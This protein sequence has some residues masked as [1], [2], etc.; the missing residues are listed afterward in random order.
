M[1][2]TAN[3]PVMLKELK[4][5]AIAR[6]WDRLAQDEKALGWRH[7]QYLSA[8]CELEVANRHSRRLA[9]YHKESKLPPGKSLSSFDFDQAVG[10]NRAHIDALAANVDWVGQARNLLL[11]GASGLGK[12][13]LACAIGASLIEQGVRVRYYPAT[14]LVQELQ[15]ARDAYRLEDHLHRLDKYGVILLDDLGY[16]KRSQGET[17]VLF[18]LVAHRYETGSLIITANQPFGDWDQIF[19]DSMMTVAAIDR[20][21]HHATII[22]LSGE[23][24]RK[25]AAMAQ[26]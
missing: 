18:E 15:R 22:E 1:P 7:E 4:L 24:Y 20:L 10:L 21:V 23:S 17:H 5:A 19:A 26:R 16:V 6:H 8:L 2:A 25:K 11:F 14:A 9:R 12:T 3:L 13:H